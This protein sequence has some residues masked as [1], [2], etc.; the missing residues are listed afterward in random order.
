M[1]GIFFGATPVVAE[2]VHKTI[3]IKI[4]VIESKQFSREIFDF[5]HYIGADLVFVDSVDE[6][7]RVVRDGDIGISYGFGLKFSRHV[8]DSFSHGIINIHTGDLPKYRGR[9]PISWAMIKGEGKIGVTIHKVDEQFDCG[10][11]IHKFYVER[12]F[13]DDLH[14]IETKIHAALTN[15]FPKA[16]KNLV[17]GDLSKIQKGDYLDRIDQVFTIVD[18]SEMQ[19]KQ[20]F[21]LF[22]SQKA[23]GGVNI[24]GQKK[25][26]CH[27]YNAVFN[28]KYDGYQIYKCADQV[29]VAIK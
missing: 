24:L 19:S 2:I 10:Y 28:N 4:I 20:L 21:S 16:I 9:H 7:L 5:S 23:Y 6:V 18:P 22:R 3:N 29:L 15:E 11:L 14:T 13:F 26:E 17:K 12:L 25:T 8:I 27:I 1:R